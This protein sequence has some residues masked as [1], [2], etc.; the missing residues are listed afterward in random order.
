MLIVTFQVKAVPGT[1]FDIKEALALQCEQIGNISFPNIEH[2]EDGMILTM[3]LN[4][5]DGSVPAFSKLM[6]PYLSKY[7]DTQILEVREVL[8]QQMEM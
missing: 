4:A 2:K 5:P 1:E 6:R 8:P 7:R 3:H